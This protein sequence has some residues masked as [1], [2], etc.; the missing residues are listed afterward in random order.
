MHTYHKQAMLCNKIHQIVVLCTKRACFQPWE[1]SPKLLK[2]QNCLTLLTT[3][4]RL[5]GG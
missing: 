4:L 5:Q 3:L 1:L 2:L